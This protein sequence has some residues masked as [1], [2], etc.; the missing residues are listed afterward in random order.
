MST[1][2][3]GG[4][5][6]YF[7]HR[8]DDL[9]ASVNHRCARSAAA[10]L[11]RRDARA[12]R[13][14]GARSSPDRSPLTT[15]SSP[16]LAAWRPHYEAHCLDRTRP[17]PGSRRS[18]PARGAPS[19]SRRASTDP[20]RGRFSPSVPAPLLGGARRRRDAPQ[21]DPAGVREIMA[22]SA[23]RPARR[24]TSGAGK[25][26]AAT[27]RAA[28]VALVAAWGLG[29]RA[30]ISAAGATVFADHAAELARWLR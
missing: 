24:R 11:A 14:G 5:S 3:T 28:G 12:H 18:S 19:R 9:H 8:S 23:P 4:L 1:S 26:D 6:R 2:F 17:T 10:A 7:P 16:A 21:P 27:A 29:S 22:R 30:D 13:R 25:V 15:S 20:W